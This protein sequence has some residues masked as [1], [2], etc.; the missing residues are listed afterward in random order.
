MNMRGIPALPVLLSFAL[1]FGPFARAAEVKAAA[2]EQWIEE[3]GGAI[4]RDSSGKIT[5]VDLRSSW[6][7]DTDLRELLKLPDLSYLDLSLT[8]ITDQGMLEIKNLPRI[9][10]LNLYFAEQVTDEGLSVIKNW[11]KLKRLNIHGTKISDTTL[12]HIAG[13]TTLESLDAGSANITDVGIE[14]MTS[15]TNLK[16]LTIGGNKIT[17]SGLQPLRQIPGLTYLDLLGRQ[18]TDSNVWVVSMTEVG[19]DAILTLK[20]LRELRLECT[21]VGVGAEGVRLATVSNMNVSSRWL[22]KMKSLSKLE[23]LK[24]QSCIRVDDD[25]MAALAAL[26]SLREVDLKGT[27]VTETGIAAL[28]SARPN[29]QVTFGPWEARTATFRNN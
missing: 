8:R 7:T 25:A 20:E 11:K 22:E 24:L 14:R 27:S 10:E 26:P 16:E 15:L 13:I 18:G 21:G 12:E 19:L 6:V 1:V 23:R 4:I 2:G 5:G 3:A 28:R 9:V 17:D 29:L